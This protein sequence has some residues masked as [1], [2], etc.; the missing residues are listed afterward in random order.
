VI[1]RREPVEA[2]V[3]DLDDTLYPERQYQSSGFRAVA[4]EME[5]LSICDRIIGEQLLLE[6]Q[7]QFGRDNVI[8]RVI[9]RL[10]A[11]STQVPFLV[12]V[13]RDHDPSGLEFYPDVCDVLVK[14]RPKYRLGVVTDGWL[15]A[16]QK[17]AAVLSLHEFVDEIVFSDEFGR[18]HWKPSATPFRACMSALD[19]RPECCVFVGDNPTR[20]VMG[21]IAAGMDAVLIR[22]DG[23]W[24]SQAECVVDVPIIGSLT[25]LPP[26]LEV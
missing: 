9:R 2:I 11:G 5:R 1:L 17:K 20:D 7:L 22:R 4:V 19:A 15:S 25:E 13:Y 21:S 6:T 23:G 24:F 18:G 10:G 8:D 14:L 12:N 3:L 26:I 16:Q